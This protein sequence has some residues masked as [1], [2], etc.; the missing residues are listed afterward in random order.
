M[1]AVLWGM[2]DNVRLPAASYA[3]GTR[4]KLKVVPLRKAPVN[5]QAVRSVDDLDDYDHPPYY[6]L[7][8]QTR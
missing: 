8:E 6:A 4:L 1:L 2:R 7:E 3:E 5:L